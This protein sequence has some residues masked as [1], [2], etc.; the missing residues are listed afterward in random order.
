IQ[1]YSDV[2]REWIKAKDKDGRIRKFMFKVDLRDIG[3]IYFYDPGL[4]EYFAVP[5]RNIHS[6]RISIWEKRKA[7]K[8]LKDK[9]IMDYDEY[10]LFDAYEQLNKIQREAVEKTKAV[11]REQASKCYHK[12]KLAETGG[13]RAKATRS[14]KADS[15]GVNTAMDELFSNVKPFEGIS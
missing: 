14:V 6:P 1:Y 13:S 7:E 9:K 15:S 4:K 10:A 8:Y 3:E 12:R 2:L 5:Y 11:R